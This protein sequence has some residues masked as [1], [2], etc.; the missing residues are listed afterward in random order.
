[1]SND[2]NI[3]GNPPASKV[4]LKRFLKRKKIGMNNN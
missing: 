2:S 4:K 1:M 3:Y